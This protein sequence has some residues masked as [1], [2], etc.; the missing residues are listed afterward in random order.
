M[1]RIFGF[2]ADWPAT[3]K[4]AWTRPAPISR[5]TTSSARNP[6]SAIRNIRIEKS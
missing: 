5:R 2:F 3:D 6:S 4:I 1:A